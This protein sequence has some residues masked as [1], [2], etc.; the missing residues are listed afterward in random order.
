MKTP[1]SRK[2]AATLVSAARKLSKTRPTSEKQL[3]EA[4]RCIVPSVNK[5][6]ENKRDLLAHSIN[7]AV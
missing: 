6:C 2:G 3:P 1:A 4:H 5:T 7:A